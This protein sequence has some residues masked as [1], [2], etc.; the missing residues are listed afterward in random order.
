MRSLRRLPQKMPGCRSIENAPIILGHLCVYCFPKIWTLKLA[1]LKSIVA[2]ADYAARPCNKY[3]RLA[4]SQIAFAQID[5]PFPIQQQRQLP[6]HPHPAYKS[7][8][9]PGF[10]STSPSAN[11][12][13]PRIT[14]SITLPR[15]S[16]PSNGLQP[17]SV[18][19]SAAS[20]VQRAFVSMTV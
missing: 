8:P 16:M 19:I 7:T 15:T 4:H 20:N 2:A 3:K 6:S 12:T 5:Q 9:S 11:A 18:C 13:S 10:A 17:Q 1:A 14:T